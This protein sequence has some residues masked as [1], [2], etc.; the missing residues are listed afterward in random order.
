MS[1]KAIRKKSSANQK[2]GIKIPVQPL[3]SDNFRSVP[4]PLPSKSFPLNKFI[5]LPEGLRPRSSQSSEESSSPRRSTPIKAIAVPS[6]TSLNDSHA[7]LYI[8]NNQAQGDD[9]LSSVTSEVFHRDDNHDPL[10][11]NNSQPNIHVTGVN[12]L[13]RHSRR[14]QSSTAITLQPHATSTPRSQRR[15]S[16]STGYHNYKSNNSSRSTTPKW[17]CDQCRICG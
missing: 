2:K 1:S 7:H 12:G 6:G 13:G 15:A 11:H 8:Y 3:F 5:A 14:D 16:P 17:K 9:R 4:K 10:L